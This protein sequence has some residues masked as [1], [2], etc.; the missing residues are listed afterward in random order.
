VAPTSLSQAFASLDLV[1]AGDNR[2]RVCVLSLKYRRT[3]ASSLR[4]RSRI[5]RCVSG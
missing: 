2:I 4:R 1:V 5:G 3:K